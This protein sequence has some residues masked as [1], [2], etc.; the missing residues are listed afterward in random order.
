MEQNIKG[1]LRRGRSKWKQSEPRSSYIIPDNHNIQGNKQ[2]SM[3]LE[4][5]RLENS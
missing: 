3:Q 1:V 2:N 4:L 5:L